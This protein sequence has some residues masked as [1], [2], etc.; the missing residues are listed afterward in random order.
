[1]HVLLAVNPTADH[2]RAGP[3]AEAIEEQV[4]R[5]GHHVVRLDADDVDMLAEL[6]VRQLRDRPDRLLIAGGDGLVHHLLPCVARSPV[7]LGLVPLGSANDFAGALGLP[8]DRAAA[9]DAAL[10]P[11]ALVDA[12]RIGDRWA[13]SVATAGFSGQVTDRANR[14]RWPRGR[15][16]YTVA[17]VLELLRLRPFP[18]VVR[19]DGQVVEGPCSLVAVANTPRFGGGMAIAPAAEPT[20]GLLDVLVVRGVGPVT[21]GLVFPRVFTGRHVHHPAV[22]TL[23]GRVVE[24]EAT[25]VDLWA[26]GER[27]GPLP[28]RLECVPGALRV[29]GATW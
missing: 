18:L 12:I 5:A 20:D 6:V 14:L 3:A 19:V 29:A 22:R 9:V 17:T 15:P 21:L 26:D 27:V 1:M 4:R 13:A 23:R 2:G 8:T 10:G 11:W 7:V 28:A 24:L 16:R 25:G